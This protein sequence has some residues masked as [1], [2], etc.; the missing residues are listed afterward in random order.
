[1]STTEDYTDRTKLLP[2]YTHGDPAKCALCHGWRKVVR[3]RQDGWE[4]T[5]ECPD[6]VIGPAISAHELR[7]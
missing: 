5:F 2:L 1:M 6:C 4:E 3:F 7:A